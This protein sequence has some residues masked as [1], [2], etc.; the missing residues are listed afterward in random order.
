MIKYT[1]RKLD[2]GREGSVEAYGPPTELGADVCYLVGHIFAQTKEM[3]E[4]AANMFRMAVIA[5][6]LPDSPTWNIS[7]NNGT[8]IRFMVP[9]KEG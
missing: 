8:T 9:Q 5:G 1:T 2:D 3:S 4:S 6:L 7:P